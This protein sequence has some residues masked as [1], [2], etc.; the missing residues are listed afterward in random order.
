[1]VNQSK[2]ACPDFLLDSNLSSMLTLTGD[3][4]HKQRSADNSLLEVA[5]M[6]VIHMKHKYKS[7][8]GMAT[9]SFQMALPQSSAV[10]PTSLRDKN[11]LRLSSHDK[12]GWTHEAWPTLLIE[13]L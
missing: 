2:M 11:L 9:F 12:G 6:V 3:L 13:I 10:A 4:L 1:M 7:G 5:G 8:N